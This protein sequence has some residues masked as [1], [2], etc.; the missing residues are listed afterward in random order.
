MTTKQTFL[1][2]P[3]VSRFIDWLH[4]GLPTVDANLNISPSPKVAR[5]SS[6][7]RTR[8]RRRRFA[9]KW[10][11]KWTIPPGRPVPSDDWATTQNS[12]RALSQALRRQVSA[13]DDQGVLAAC[14]AI[15]RWGGDR[16]PRR[17]AYPFL[18]GLSQPAQYIADVSARLG[19]RALTSRSCRQSGA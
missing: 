1:K 11:A 13:S 16:N 8:N 17:G 12:L 2:D 4:A 15:L 18:H 10:K 3:D 9:L 19:F 7:P 5:G 14:D 6:C